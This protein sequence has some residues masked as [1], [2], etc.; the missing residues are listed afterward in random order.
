M[1]TSS[2]LSPT[3][4][5]PECK[6]L[7]WLKKHLGAEGKANNVSCSIELPNELMQVRLIQ[8]VKSQF[9]TG[10][11][12]LRRAEQKGSMCLIYLENLCRHLSYILYGKRILMELYS[13]TGSPHLAIVWDSN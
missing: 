8:V 11:Q 3:H 12:Q 10:T 9:L 6:F 1:I 5:N 7:N 2:A 4:C 13:N